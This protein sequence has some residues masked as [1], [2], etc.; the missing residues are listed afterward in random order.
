MDALAAIQ[1]HRQWKERLRSAMATREVLD[2]A[3][4]GADCHCAFG[5]W[6][7]A[8]GLQQFGT[9]AGWQQVV[10]THA[11]FHRAAAEVAAKINEG[12]LLEADQ[13]MASGTRYAQTSADLGVAV[14]ALFNSAERSES[15]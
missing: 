7:H 10:V 2:L 5:K 13:M 9:T 11:E 1:A 8:E 3:T 12:K 14:T 6:L 15:C 4:I